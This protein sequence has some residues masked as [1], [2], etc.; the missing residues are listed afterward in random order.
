MIRAALALVALLVGVLALQWKDWPPAPSAVGLDLPAGTGGESGAPGDPDP[1]ARLTPPEPRDS[2]ASVTERPLFRPERKPEEP[3]PE[4]AADETQ[5]EVATSLDGM[6]VSAVII[7]PAVVAAW[8]RDPKAPDLKRLR[9]GDD[10]EGWSVKE[11]QSDRVVLE[12]QGE[13][14]ELL[15]RDFSKAQAPAAPTPPTARAR[16]TPATQRQGPPQQ[17]PNVP[18]TLPRRPN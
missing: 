12:R 2:Y 6:D 5:P 16:P 9:L 15:L 14:D 1:L 7:T 4:D 17:G 11:I 18:R 13:L 3:Q 10:L 8:I